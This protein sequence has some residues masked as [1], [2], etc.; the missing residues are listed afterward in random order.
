MKHRIMVNDTS[1]R[2]FCDELVERVKEFPKARLTAC[3]VGDNKKVEDSF[4][5]EAV[6]E[7]EE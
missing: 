6:L 3:Q 1:F 4:L 2:R 7:F 5:F